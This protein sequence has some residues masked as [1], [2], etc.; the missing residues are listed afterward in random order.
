MEIVSIW[1]VDVMRECMNLSMSN[2]SRY[3]FVSSIL[4]LRDS[5]CGMSTWFVL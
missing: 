4:T 3:R 1:L 2:C 5:E